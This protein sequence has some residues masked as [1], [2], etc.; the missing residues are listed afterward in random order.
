MKRSIWKR[1]HTL[2][3]MKSYM[4]MF[5]LGYVLS[6]RIAQVRD[7]GQLVEY[8]VSMPEAL[9]LGQVSH[10]SRRDGTGL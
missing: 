9:I 7:T 8:W 6:Q 4:T 5:I 10:K 3:L 1:Q 2:S